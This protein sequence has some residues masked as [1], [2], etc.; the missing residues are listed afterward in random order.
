MNAD[1]DAKPRCRCRDFQM[2]ETGLMLKI[3]LFV[4][5]FL[6]A[7]LAEHTKTTAFRKCHVQKQLPGGVL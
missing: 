6:F 1:G 4:L 3:I 2:A 5:V 7:L